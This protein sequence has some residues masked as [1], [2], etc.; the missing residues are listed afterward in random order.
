M[1]NRPFMG[2][3]AP[4]WR[5][6]ALELARAGVFF[7]VMLLL[8]ILMLSLPGC[9]LVVIPDPE[10]TPPPPDE[11]P[12]VICPPG[13]MLEN[14]ICVSIPPPP[15][16]TTL[17][18]PPPP[19]PPPS[20]FQWRESDD[21]DLCVAAVS[22]ANA[23]LGIAA[24]SAAPPEFLADVEAMTREV[25][26]VQGESEATYYAR[27]VPACQARGLH[28]AL[29]GEE[30][31]VARVKGASENY[32]RILNSGKP[33][34]GMGSF[35]SRCFPATRSAPLEAPTGGLVTYP[36]PV[37][38]V[39]IKVHTPAAQRADGLALMDGV[40]LARG[41]NAQF[42][43]RLFWPACGPEGSVGREDCD[44]ALVV[45]WEGRGRN[46]KS[47]PWLY[48]AKPGTMVRACVGAICSEPVGAH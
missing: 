22:E 20:T 8:L 2:E 6:Y 7:M 18:P 14:G 38:Q 4:S 31:A 35:R 12:V 1:H 16:P 17:P 36:A 15:P 3:R 26:L 34:V 43:G 11:E 28:C 19:P 40:A 41:D 42:P 30:L 45:R 47:N 32:D 44:R 29:Y 33:R 27:L 5:W 23:D 25:P 10:P 21:S 37:A 13:M 48:H 46:H 9:G 39:R 24:S